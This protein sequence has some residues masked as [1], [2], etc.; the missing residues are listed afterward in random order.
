VR[1]ALALFRVSAD[2]LESHRQE[3]AEVEVP[4]GV[5]DFNAN[6]HLALTHVQNDI[7]R[8]SSVENILRTWIETQIQEVRTYSIFISALPSAEEDIHC[9]NDYDITF[10]NIVDLHDLP[11]ISLPL[12]CF[13]HL[14]EFPHARSALLR[15][16]E[17][18][19]SQHGLNLLAGRSSA[20]SVGWTIPW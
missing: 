20:A 16:N 15:W 8:H 11:R 17:I 12:P 1:R 14:E 13:V 4:G 5:H 3:L 6:N 7:I 9:D 19:R 10:D 2:P 18:S